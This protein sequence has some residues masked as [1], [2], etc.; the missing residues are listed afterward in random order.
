[1]RWECGQPASEP[2]IALWVC[3]NASPAVPLAFGSAGLAERTLHV[4]DAML[5]ARCTDLAGWYG[6]ERAISGML[7]L[8]FPC[9]AE[10]R[11]S[12]K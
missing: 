5:R 12:E 7:S 4:H 11:C 6:G 2:Q 9:S 8:A 3:H 1:V 10:V